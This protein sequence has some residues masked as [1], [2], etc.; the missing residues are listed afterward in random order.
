MEINGEQGKLQPL[1]YVGD[2]DKIAIGLPEPI[3]TQTTIKCH[4]DTDIQ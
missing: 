4:F 3:S 1:D 2:G